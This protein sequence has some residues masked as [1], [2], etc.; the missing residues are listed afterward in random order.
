M[1]AAWSV[2]IGKNRKG[3]GKGEEE[4]GERLCGF[5][6]GLGLDIWDTASTGFQA[7]QACHGDND[8]ATS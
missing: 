4:R 2:K 8:S 6:I 3:R 5:W 1:M 7:P